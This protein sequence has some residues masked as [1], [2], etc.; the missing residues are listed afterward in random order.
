V[1]VVSGGKIA[2]EQYADGFTLHTAQRTW[3]VAKSLTATLIGVVAQQGWI[4]AD[5]YA[6]IPE[7]DNAV[8]DPR[9]NITVDHLLRMSSGLYTPDPGS[10]TDALYFGGGTVQEL[11]TGWPVEVAP[12]TRFRYSN[13]DT[14][15]AVR[16][17][18]ANAP[19]EAEYQAWP[20]QFF[21]SIGMTRTIAERDWRG[22]FMLSSQVWTTARDLARFGMLYL[23]QGQWNG[24]RLLPLDWDKDVVKPF[25][26]QPE[27]PFG[28]GMSFWLLNHSPGVPEDTFAAFGNRGQYVVIVPSRQVVI[29]RRAEDPAGSDFDIARF[30]ADVLAAL[31]AKK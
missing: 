23:N 25:G 6:N 26:P 2:A 29:V 31:P 11:A 15:L 24:Q 19:S 13:T 16:A 30:A 22:N 9:R 14:L 12:G 20:G 10:R 5:N 21:A 3:A 18:R 8:L 7:W 27:G 1:V 4:R 17:V 28:Y